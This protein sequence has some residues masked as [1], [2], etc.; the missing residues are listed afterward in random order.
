MRTRVQTIAVAVGADVSFFLGKGPAMVQ[1]IGEILTDRII[2][3]LPL[4][5]CRPPVQIPT[6]QAYGW[7]DEDQR[8]TPRSGNA[9]TLPKVGSHVSITAREIVENLHNDLE[10]VVEARHPDIQTLKKA[11]RDRGAIGT[12]MSGSG[13]C[14]F[15]IFNSLSDA[16][17]AHQELTKQ[18][19]PPDHSFF[20]CETLNGLQ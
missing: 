14:V 15:G 10:S 20:V 9:T 17:K 12:L 3:K 11:L 4:V 13:S 19:P 6:S 1:G 7:F 2:Q 18:F 8:L 16:Q 5:V